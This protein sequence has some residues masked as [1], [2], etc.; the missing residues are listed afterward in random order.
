MPDPNPKIKE[1]AVAISV[2]YVNAYGTITK[3]LDKIQTASTPP[4]FT[5]D[6]L[7]TK[8]AL[9][10][11]SAKPVIPFL[12]RTGFLHGD[13][14]PTELYKQFR[15]AK[16]RGAAAAQAIRTGYATLY[17]LN[18]YAHELND[19]DLKG[20]VVQATG[21]DANSVTAKSIVGSFKALK[22]FADFEASGL[23]DEPSDDADA[24]STS[25]QPGTK[26]PSGSIKLGYTINLNLPAT[27]DIAVFNAIFKSLR[28][29]LID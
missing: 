5:Q 1:P 10:G 11:G 3:A 13:G 6:F 16:L 26:I 19:K 27:S 17:E 20:V 15:N 29:H 22:A 12:K 23:T 24:A 14:A 7:A 2:P 21:L 4:R 8:L 28:D 9:P 25:T 18:E